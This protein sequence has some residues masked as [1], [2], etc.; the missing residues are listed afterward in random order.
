[1]L[2]LLYQ[3]SFEIIQHI[4]GQHLIYISLAYD[5]Y[6]INTWHVYGYWNQGL[7]LGFMETIVFATNYHLTL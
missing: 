3:L 7:N 1:M 2:L 4:Y 6:M 5:M